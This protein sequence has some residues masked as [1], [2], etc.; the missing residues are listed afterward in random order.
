MASINKQWLQIKR[1]DYVQEYFM[2][3]EFIQ[4][5]NWGRSSPPNFVPNNYPY[6]KDCI[7]F[8][9]NRYGKDVKNEIRVTEITHGTSCKNMPSIIKDGGFKPNTK[10]I[11]GIGYMDL[12]WFGLKIGE[13]EIDCVKEKYK[14]SAQTL[15]KYG[16]SMRTV[17]SVTSHFASTA[18]FQPMSRYGNFKFTL[19]IQE[20]LH[21][22]GMQFCQISCGRPL[23]RKLGTFAYKMETMHVILVCPPGTY[24]TGQ[25]PLLF[26]DPIIQP[27]ENL[28]TWIWR[29]HST[30]DQGVSVTPSGDVSARFKRWEHVVFAFY[31][32]KGRYLRIDNLNDHLSMCLWQHMN[33]EVIGVKGAIYTMIE[34]IALEEYFI[35][36]SLANMLIRMIRGYIDEMHLYVKTITSGLHKDVFIIDLAWVEQKLRDLLQMEFA[37][38]NWSP[39]KG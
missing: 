3:G 16:L 12:V 25:C 14:W 4:S 39:L 23:M 27:D 13:T 9:G 35:R 7:E 37:D 33:C 30:G 5:D 36:K 38:L 22:Y 10:Y 15:L 2:I 1:S 18:P 21:K 20:V 32:P 34:S 29:P 24:N 31:V 28:G 19:S 8:C 26:G 11:P 17:D 6:I